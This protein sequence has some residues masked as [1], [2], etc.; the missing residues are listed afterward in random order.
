M[1]TEDFKSLKPGKLSEQELLRLNSCSSPHIDWLATWVNKRFRCAHC[2]GCTRRCEVLENSNLDIGLVEAAYERITQQ[3]PQ[4]Q[5]V[6]VRALAQEQPELYHALRRCCFCGFCT[7]LCETHARSPERMR[8][9]RELFAQAG[10]LKPQDSQLVMVDEQWHIFSAYRAVYAI[11][12]PEFI[13][14]EEAAAHGPG[15][16]DTLLLPGCSLVSYAPELVR[17]LGQTLSAAGIA[18]ALSDTCCGSPLMSIGLFER[19]QALRSSLADQISEAGISHVLTICPGCGEELCET[20]DG[21]AEILP[22][23]ELLLEIPA[24]SKGAASEEAVSSFELPESI[25]FFDSCHDR[26]DRRHGRAIRKL[27]RQ[28]LPQSEQLEM[29]HRGKYTLCCGAGGAVAGYDGEITNRRVWRVIEEA[30]ATG[31]ATLVCACPTCSYTIAQAAL[32]SGGDCGIENRH[33]LEL[34]LG[35]EID[36][37]KVFGQLGDMWSGEYG[38][39]LT[40]T[41]FS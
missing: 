4:E 29:G 21:K 36:W 35:Q 33:Y 40:Q 26:F 18:W 19:A 30:K 5:A 27:L 39:W 34:V 11:A 10:L 22:L 12:Y 24:K 23:P 9:W 41:F 2:K 8:E 7:S 3:K 32:D 6:A 14:L 16:V 38:P 1:D 37:P 15:L 17:K 25:T 28:S 13:Q 31:A 20:I